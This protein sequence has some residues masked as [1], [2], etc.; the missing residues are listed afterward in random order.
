MQRKIQEKDNSVRAMEA[1]IGRLK[2]EI[3]LRLVEKDAIIK[4]LRDTTQ[5]ISTELRDKHN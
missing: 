1:E 5:R 2:E 3:E 4:G